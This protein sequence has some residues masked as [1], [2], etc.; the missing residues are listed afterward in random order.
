MTEFYMNKLVRDAIPG[1]MQAENQAPIYRVLTGKELQ[2]AL[3]EKLKEE[4]DEALASI[5]DDQEFMSEL[6]DV[7]EVLD[8]LIHVRGISPAKLAK[9][10]SEKRTK[11]GAFSEG[12]FIEA[13]TLD[14]TSE[15]ADYY[16]SQPL[17]YQEVLW[18]DGTQQQ[19]NTP[20]SIEKG[21]YQ[22]YKGNFYDVLGVGCHSET[23]EYFVVYRALYKKEV[24]PEI[25]IRPYDM[26]VGSVEKNG[27]SFPRFQKI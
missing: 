12:Y 24:S 13:I 17:R 11:R 3:L 7:R 14:D 25:W 5:D 2:R 8:E 19:P 6:A 18:S 22:H 10:R 27:S 15:W 9:A 1:K 21:L 20:P 26:F 16:R 4:A 23:L